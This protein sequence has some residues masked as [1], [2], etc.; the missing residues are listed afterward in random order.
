MSRTAPVLLAVA[1]LVA[2]A[3]CGG[4][5]P[6]GDATPSRDA[7]LEP[8]ESPYDTPL[9]DSDLLADHEAALRDAETV[10]VV[11]NTT[12]TGTGPGA[13]FESLATARVSLADGRVYLVE[14]PAPVTQTYRY[15]NDTVFSRS[16]GGTS[17]SRA[18][19]DTAGRTAVEWTRAPLERLLPL[20][21]FTHRGVTE[22]D[23]ERVH[24][25]RATDP[26]AVN[27]STVTPGDLT[28]VELTD[29]NVTLRVR[30]SGAVG[31]LRFAYTVEEGDQRR[32]VATSVTFSDLGETDASPPAWVADLRDRFADDE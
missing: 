3:G 27:T 10:T 23:G 19:N 31:R 32:E 28:G 22:R 15:A 26:A 8:A 6:G 7:D 25:Y 4:V 18:E 29:V 12:I 14:R 20:A 1:A 9:E 11:R 13:G 24:V 16:A 21:S 30:E 2:L 17:Y 5:L